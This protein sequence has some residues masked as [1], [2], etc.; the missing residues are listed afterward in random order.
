[1]DS[2]VLNDGKNMTIDLCLQKCYNYLWAGVEYGREC[3]CGNKLNLAGNK[4]ATPG[5]NVTKTECNMLCS[6]D[7]N[8][9]CGAGVRLSLYSNNATTTK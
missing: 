5:K 8:V 3:W 6:G 2:Q 1:M 7:K 4:A 9:Y